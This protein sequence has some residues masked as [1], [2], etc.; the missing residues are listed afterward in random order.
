M[1]KTIKNKLQKII[2]LHELKVKNEL[3][4]KNLGLLNFKFNKEKKFDKIQDYEFQTF[5]QFGDDGIIS[6]LI[7]NLKLKN[8]KFI[9]FGVENYEEANTRFLLECFN[10]KGL[11][12]D[13]N[14]DYINYI[15][16]QNYYWRNN[17]EVIHSF[18][19]KENIN[20]IIKNCNF[21]S[22]IGVLSIDIDGNDYWVW[23][24]INSVDP[25][26]VIIEY[27]ARFGDEL[28]VTIPYEKNFNRENKGRSNIYYGASLKAL[29]KLANKKNYSLICTNSNGNN[30]YFVK[31]N[32]MPKD[33]HLIKPRTPK[34]CFNINSF[35][36]L[37]DKKN[38]FIS[39]TKEKEF[40]I[41][42]KFK[43]IEV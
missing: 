2:G 18:I 31:N 8:N 28:S 43:L 34:E 14:I 16:K 29:F 6:Y 10:W 9:E 22:D 3:I 26:I 38:N 42:N 21:S 39:L 23:E 1:K 20:L 33:H 30:A 32:I 4:L 5:S 15:K 27:N 40:E 24:N 12:I 41:I 36:E 25:S 35:K 17:L 13:S 11:I 37:K 19:T 7:D